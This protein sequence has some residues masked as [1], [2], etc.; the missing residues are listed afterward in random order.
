MLRSWNL[1]LYNQCFLTYKL[2]QSCLS[3]QKNQVKPVGYTWAELGHR[4]DYAAISVNF[5]YSRYSTSIFVSPTIK[6]IAY[7]YIPLP[8]KKLVYLSS[9]D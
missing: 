1:R 6:T 4:L 7:P 8:K 5:I 2:W 3:S 9:I